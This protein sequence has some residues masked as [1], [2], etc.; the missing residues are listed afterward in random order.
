MLQL[1]KVVRG[2]VAMTRTTVIAR[3]AATDQRTLDQACV[4]CLLCVFPEFPQE[5]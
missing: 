2:I 1:C 4:K 3:V 5:S